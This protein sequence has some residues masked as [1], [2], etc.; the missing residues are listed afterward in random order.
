MSV[1]VS[2]IMHLKEMQPLKLVAGANGL[3][4]KVCG[5]GILDYEYSIENGQLKIN[6][7][8]RRYDFIITSFLFANNHP[9]MLLEA[10]KA[11]AADHISAI[12]VKMVIFQKLPEEV[13][14][15]ANQNRI[16]VFQFG[17]ED[18]YIEDLIT[19]IKN[20][21]KDRTRY[22][23]LEHQ[24]SLFLQD[25]LDIGSRREFARSLLPDRR[26]RYFV[27]YFTLKEQ[28]QKEQRDMHRAY[29]L[30]HERTCYYEGGCFV[31]CDW[32]DSRGEK[33]CD[34]KRIYHKHI[35]W[36]KE[37]LAFTP[38]W[39]YVSMSD[40]F[41]DVDDV[42]RAMQEAICVSRYI[43]MTGGD[44]ACFSETGLYRIL[45][46]LYGTEWFRDFSSSIVDKI[47][48]FDREFDAALYVT[49][50]YYVKAAGNINAVADSLHIHQNTVRYRINK[51]REI[52]GM[53][54]DKNFEVEL[55]LAILADE[56][57]HI[58]KNLY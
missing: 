20:N 9:E 11:L 40:I 1:T 36:F 29:K 52:L 39:Y 57:N 44:S 41:E 32:L 53:E 15:Y 14:E 50:K 16:P 10:I 54:N 22:D 42:Q 34:T 13:I 5:V 30:N 45:L 55:T 51:I 3:N 21:I 23:Y 31:I 46:P 24:T 4:N 37:V 18:M 26:S 28:Y 47:L 58:Y 8:F 27:I 49:S 2:E 56:L 33:S 7:S 48:D 19:L 12:A 43:A 6:W 38:A 25:K 35:D 17:R